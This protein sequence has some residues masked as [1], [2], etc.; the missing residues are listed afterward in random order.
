M[1]SR[2]ALGTG[3]WSITVIVE[4]PCH[5][6]AAPLLPGAGA[7]ATSEQTSTTWR[8]SAAS[9]ATVTMTIA[10]FH[11]AAAAGSVLD[12]TAAVG[13]NPGLALAADP[14]TRWTALHHAVK[15]GHREVCA[16]LLDAGGSV[17]A[18]TQHD[19]SALHIAACNQQR[20]VAE[21]LIQRGCP[22]EL[23]DNKLNTALLRA[24][25]HGSLD[26]FLLLQAAGEVATSA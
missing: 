17:T 7:G 11:D 3:P 14:E 18:T 2:S 19:S 5:G 4:D 24:A 15:H 13:A 10:A 16:V 8:H 23:L 25:Q 12:V 22:L 6:Q 21:L 26:V 20:D 1:Y 9:A